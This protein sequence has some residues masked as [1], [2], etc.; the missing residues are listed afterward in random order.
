MRKSAAK[1]YYPPQIQ[2]RVDFGDY[3]QRRKEL[4]ERGK[5]WFDK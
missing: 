3:T 1:K 5:K 4:M 2:D